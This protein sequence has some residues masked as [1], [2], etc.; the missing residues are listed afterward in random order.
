MQIYTIAGFNADATALPRTTILYSKGDE[1]IRTNYPF[2]PADSNEQYV[3][4][5]SVAIRIA[6]LGKEVAERFSYRYIDSIGIG[7]DIVALNKLTLLHE[8]GLPWDLATAFHDA[9]ATTF[10]CELF[11]GELAPNYSISFYED[12]P[13]ASSNGYSIKGT[14][15][16]KALSMLS[17]HRKIR[18]GDILLLH[19]LLPHTPKPCG[20]MFVECEKN[21]QVTLSIAG[22]QRFS[23]QLRVK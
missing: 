11:N 20:S 21:Y 13:N 23:A 8:H 19:P 14:I 2:Y 4:F 9:V 1:Q 18:Q 10:P 5:P 3:V 16:S 6:K 17:Y 12:I 22:E 15:V 7:F